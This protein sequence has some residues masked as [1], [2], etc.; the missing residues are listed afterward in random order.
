M[1]RADDLDTSQHGKWEEERREL[2]E[3]VTQLEQDND[4]LYI[5][6]GE[7]E[8]ELEAA[9]SG[10]PLSLYS[11]QKTNGNSESITTKQ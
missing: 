8:E 7:M 4:D 5:L 6:V 3:R 9:R 10:M 11:H 2:L 1:R